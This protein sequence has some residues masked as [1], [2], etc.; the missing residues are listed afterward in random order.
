A[1]GLQQSARYNVIAGNTIAYGATGGSLFLS[2]TVGERLA[3]R[4]SGAT[5]VVEGCGDHGL[6]YMTGGVAVVLGA[7]GWN[8][9]AGMSGGIAFVLDPDVRLPS[10]HNPAMVE[11]FPVGEGP[12]AL[13]YQTLL[14]R[15]QEVTGSVLA[16]ELL[17]DW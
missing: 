2:G 3:V 5:V 14:Q 10:R 9:G 13:L 16:K 7:T 8:F 17:A 6:E 15:H 1:P 11:L 12:T 4:N